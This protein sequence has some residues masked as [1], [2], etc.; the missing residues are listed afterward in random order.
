MIQARK[1]MRRESRLVIA[2]SRALKSMRGVIDTF[3]V[4]VEG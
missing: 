3:N 2:R 1:E 4:T